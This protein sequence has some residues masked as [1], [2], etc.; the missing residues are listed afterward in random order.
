[1]VKKLITA[2]KTPPAAVTSQ[3]IGIWVVTSIPPPS[4]EYS[5]SGPEA[6]S[7]VLDQALSFDYV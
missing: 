7:S 2:T 3:V 6:S 5:L 1:M 4:V